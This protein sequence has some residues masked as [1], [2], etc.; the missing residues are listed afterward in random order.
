M[1]LF[2]H[3][4]ISA[5]IRLCIRLPLYAYVCTCVWGHLFVC[6]YLC[7]HVCLMCVLCVFWICLC[8][9][10]YSLLHICVSLCLHLF[11]QLCQYCG[12]IF[13]YKNLLVIF[14][15]CDYIKLF[16]LIFVF[17]C[18]GVFPSCLHLSLCKNICISCVYLGYKC[19]P[20]F[21]CDLLVLSVCCNVCSLLYF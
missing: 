17:V 3:L 6:I 4:C 15:I 16:N 10:L 7:I 14:Y 21:L 5:C 20:V 1:Y 9:C 8:L 19:V 11:I 18:I 12:G 13:I 2:S